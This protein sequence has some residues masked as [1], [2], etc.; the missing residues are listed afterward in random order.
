MVTAALLLRISF[1]MEATH[2]VSIQ[3]SATWPNNIKVWAAA[4]APVAHC[5]S[6]NALCATSRGPKLLLE[7]LV[8]A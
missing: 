4:E 7:M 1:K 8:A 2:L 6:W 5:R 3:L